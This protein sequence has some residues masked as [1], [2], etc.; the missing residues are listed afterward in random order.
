MV[1]E[2]WSVFGGEEKGHFHLQK[3]KKRL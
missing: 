2:N 3:E 1:V